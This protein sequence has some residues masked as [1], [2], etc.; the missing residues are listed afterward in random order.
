VNPQ[1]AAG[2]P[3]QVGDVLI[4]YK[5]SSSKHFVGPVLTDDQQGLVHRLTFPGRA[6]AVDAARG[7]VMP[8][9]HIYLK[10]TDTGAW[11]KVESDVGLY[12]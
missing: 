5:D 4:L 3:T 7:L 6:T 10:N 11:V 1:M 8:K 9:R 12:E 2:V